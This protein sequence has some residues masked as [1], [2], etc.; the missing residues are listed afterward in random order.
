MF[1]KRIAIVVAIASSLPSIAFGAEKIRAQLSWISTVQYADHW[2]AKEKDLFEKQGLDVELRPGGPN[3]VKAP[4]A[5]A[6]G[7]ADIGYTDWQSF[8]GAIRQGNDFV[9]IGVPMYNSPM[10]ILS[11]KAH[12]IQKPEDISGAKILTQ[13]PHEKHLIEAV[14]S[15]AKKKPDDWV[16]VPAGY[17]PDPLLAGDGVG[18]TAYATNQVITLEKMGLKKGQDFFFVSFED[19]GFAEPGEVIFTTRTY[20][21]SHRDTLVKYIAALIEG[22][23]LN[24]QDPTYAP[25]LV[26]EKYGSDLGLDLDQQ[27][28]QNILQMD[29]RR[30][31]YYLLDTARVTGPMMDAARAAGTADLP[32][33]PENL[34]DADVVREAHQSL[35]AS[36]K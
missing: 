36:A 19:L 35:Q 24:V 27:N 28:R 2:I 22:W 15:L 4:V 1:L 26:V 10:G 9:L 23:R 6:A 25:K 13:G 34:V 17:S 33:H 30:E 21:N 11:L 29:L 5:V 7:A 32:A 12:P 16:S 14:L 8:L 18:Y 3:A 31:P 20:L